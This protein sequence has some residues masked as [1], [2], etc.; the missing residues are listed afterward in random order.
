MRTHMH[1]HSHSY[2]PHIPIHVFPEV[3]LNMQVTG[4][5]RAPWER[6]LSRLALQGQ[7]PCSVETGHLELHLSF[8]HLLG[9]NTCYQNSHRHLPL[10]GPVFWSCSPE[11]LRETPEA[12]K[13]SIPMT[14]VEGIS[15]SLGASS[16]K[17]NRAESGGSGLKSQLCKKWSRGLQKVQACPGIN[18]RPH[19][20]NN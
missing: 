18:T 5:H 9:S 11:G 15:T 16:K 6:H 20:K 14:I 8:P 3:G 10:H 19:S 1:T 2:A 17:E 4:S 13:S 7:P 12:I